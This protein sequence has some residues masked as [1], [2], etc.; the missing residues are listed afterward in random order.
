MRRFEL[1]QG[2]KASFWE[3]EHYDDVV[4]TRSGTIGGRP[5]R[6][7]EKEYHD[8]MAAEVDFDKQIH[9][10][11][12]A[13]WTEV[14][15]ASEPLAPFEER[16]L[17]LQP[18]DGS[19]AVTFSGPAVAYLLWRMV[20][21]E[22][23]DRHRPADDLSRWEGRAARQL[24]LEGVPTPGAEGYEDWLN[25]YRELSVRDRTGRMKD[26]MIGA[27]KYRQGSHWIC[28]AKEAELIATEAPNRKPKRK[29]DKKEQ[30]QWVAEW[31]SFHTRVRKVGYEIVPV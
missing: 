24:G 18:L 20:E 3:I 19:E 27:F 15:E 1:I 31:C 22:L 2:N 16:P 14:E 17:S 28:G 8:D 7:R 5:P 30:A 11:R 25:R 23:F 10:K 29:K 26:H 6:E 21:V 13:G 4:V 9:A 12:R